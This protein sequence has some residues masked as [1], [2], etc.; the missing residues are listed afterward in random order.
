MYSNAQLAVLRDTQLGL[1]YVPPYLMTSLTAP[2]YTGN[3]RIKKTPL[4]MEEI[5]VFLQK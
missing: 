4:N 3:E 5:T 1:L 2:V